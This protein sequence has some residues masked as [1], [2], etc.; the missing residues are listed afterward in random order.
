[1]STS[2]RAFNIRI[3]TRVAGV[4][5]T[6]WSVN[7][8]TF[9]RGLTNDQ[10]G[11]QGEAIERVE[12][13][14]GPKVLTIDANDKPWCQDLL[15][16]QERKALGEVEALESAIEVTF[17][18]DYGLQGSRRYLMADCVVSDGTTTFAGASERVTNAITF[19]DPNPLKRLP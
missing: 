15:D 6:P 11:V 12:S 8:G 14:P 18:L 2:T 7:S 5:Q 17:A 13:V 9:A 1:M 19:T 16:L 10:F 3:Q 4:P